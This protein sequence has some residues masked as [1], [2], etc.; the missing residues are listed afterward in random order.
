[1]PIYEYECKK[2]GAVFEALVLG[3]ETPACEKCG[4]R[5]LKKLVSTFAAVPGQSAMPQCRGSMPSCSR[6]R[7]E[8]GACP[9]MRLG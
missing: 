7:C 3:K 6:S 8:S 2:C 5:S 1:M 9:G 4:S